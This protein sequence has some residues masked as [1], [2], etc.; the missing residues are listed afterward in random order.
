MKSRYTRCLKGNFASN[1][2]LRLTKGRDELGNR[3]SMYIN[4]KPRLRDE[5]NMNFC[6]VQL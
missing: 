2:S 6:I 3:F 5:G 1:P 4:F